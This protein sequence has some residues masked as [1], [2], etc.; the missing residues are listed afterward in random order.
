M[1]E[2]SV[3][4]L[5]RALGPKLDDR[6]AERLRSA[7]IEVKGKLKVAYPVASWVQA[8]WIAG[9]TLAPGM[10][11]DEATYQVGR[12]FIQAYES[13]LMG[14]AA[15]TMARVVGPKR[16]LERMTRNFRTG[17]SY[18]TSKLTELGPG[19]F[20]LW[21]APVSVPGFYRGVVEAGLE[22]AGARSPKVQL[23]RWEQPE[24][25]VFDVTWS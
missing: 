5:I 16:T 20:E 11:K 8:L 7:G 22:I 13:T 1:F 24:E 2:Q 19:K 18:G 15:Y 6:C 10:G 25:A 9:E 3:E 4:G 21:C 14:K 12:R 17:S 23:V